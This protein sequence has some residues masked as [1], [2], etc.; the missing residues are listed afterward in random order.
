MQR[1]FQVTLVRDATLASCPCRSIPGVFGT[2]RYREPEAFFG[3]AA[4]RRH[5]SSAP[6]S[7]QHDP[8][9]R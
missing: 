7:T 4:P 1:T 5:R 6:N 8:S 3:S 9:E 2:V